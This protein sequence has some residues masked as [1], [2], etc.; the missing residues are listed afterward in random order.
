MEFVD[1]ERTRPRNSISELIT[2]VILINLCAKHTNN[3]WTAV[4]CVWCTQ[5]STAQQTYKNRSLMKHEIAGQKVSAPQKN[6]CRIKWTLKIYYFLTV[7]HKGSLKLATASLKM[8]SPSSEKRKL[9]QKKNR[10]AKIEESK[11]Q[12]SV[13]LLLVFRSFRSLD[14]EYLMGLRYC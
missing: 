12:I 13:C 4:C 2:F 7:E 3:I 11:R 9:K 10:G 1:G 5:H 6:I 8:E 14:T